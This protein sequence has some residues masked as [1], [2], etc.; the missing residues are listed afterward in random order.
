[1]HGVFSLAV[2]LGCWKGVKKSVKFWSVLR[3]T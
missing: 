3:D 2:I 1:M